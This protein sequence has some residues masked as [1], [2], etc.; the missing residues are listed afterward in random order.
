MTRITLSRG[1]RA[2]PRWWRF[3]RRL[4]ITTVLSGTLAGCISP[5]APSPSSGPMTAPADAGL[6]ARGSNV[7]KPTTTLPSTVDL[8]ATKTSN[9]LQTKPLGSNP[10]EST[11]APAADLAVPAIPRPLSEY[12]VDLP[13]ALRL[14]EHENPAIGAARARVGEALA[15]RQKA[16]VELLPWLNAGVDYDGHVGNV[17]Q[18]SGAI[19]N[20]SRQALYFG[21][22]A[23][24]SSTNSIMIPA[25]SIVESL[26][27]AIYDPLAAHQRVEQSR[28]D[29]AA[30]S[31]SVLLEVTRYYFELLGATARLAAD[32][33]SAKDAEK[34]MQITSRYAQ[35]GEGRPADFHRSETQWRIR[36]GEVR[37]TEEDV[38][39]AAARLSR[40]LHLDP[41]IRL[42]PATRIL[43]I[44]ALV[45]LNSDTEALLGVAI[46]QRP[47]IRAATADLGAHRVRLKQSIARPFL[48]T[49]L[50]GFSG[51]AFGGGS[52][53]NPPLVGNFAG[54]TDF[55]VG[56][57]W[58]LE[59]L[60]LGNLL[61]Q[62]R[63]RAAV[64]EAVGRQ[65]RTITM[66]RAQVAE[67]L[68]EALANR[69]QVEIARQGLATASDGF[70][71]DLLGALEAVPNRI[72]SAARPVEVVNSLNLLAEARRRLIRV[73]IDYNQAQFRL[74][75]AMGSPPP[76]E[77]PADPAIPGVSISE[78]SADVTRVDAARAPARD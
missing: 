5:P 17:Q 1:I 24:T 8:S 41:A 63:E 28:Y 71:R 34:V 35:T 54:R 70:Q 37:R 49:V 66:V 32:Q 7:G 67:A 48:P 69:E 52:N 75:V 45:D 60:G 33:Q 46:N 12:A 21:G 14:A 51:G 50:L 38:A 76:L 74:F 43:E 73:I 29:A 3:R 30:T 39:V 4:L 20:V 58:T 23:W 53:L 61:E 13:S 25:V 9:E 78:L 42:K 68:G 47:E 2:G 36:R 57:Y 77:H 26:A 40:R 10:A 27:N 64:G 62:K 11:P 19:L 55:D 22:G 72:G 18:S 56:A 65:S 16:C 31:N 15:H 59:N 44:V 6:R